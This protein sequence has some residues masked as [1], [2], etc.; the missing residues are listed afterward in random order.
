MLKWVIIY[1][2]PFSD[3]SVEYNTWSYSFIN[4]VA[5]KLLVHIQNCKFCLKD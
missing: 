3:H 4:E 5:K 2:T 1:E